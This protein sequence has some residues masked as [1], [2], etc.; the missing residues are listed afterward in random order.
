MPQYWV[1]TISP[2]VFSFYFCHHK[3]T[4]TVSFQDRGCQQKIEFG[5]LLGTSPQTQD[6]PHCLAVDPMRNTAD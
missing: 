4:T 3:T 6:P 5:D 1:V 2:F